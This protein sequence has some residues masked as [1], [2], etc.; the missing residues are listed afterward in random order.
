LQLRLVRLVRW[1][2]WLLHSWDDS[3]WEVRM[4]VRWLLHAKWKLVL[5]W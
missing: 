5:V 4:V 2:R 3:D 1:D